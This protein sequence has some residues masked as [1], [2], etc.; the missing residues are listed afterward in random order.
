MSTADDLTSALSHLVKARAAY[1]KALDN[2]QYVQTG[3]R[4]MATHD[5]KELLDAVKYWQAEVN[6]LEAL[7]NG[8]ARQNI[9]PPLRFN[10]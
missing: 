6:R 5:L 4:R 10:L 9:N 8:T 3:Q 2:P 7:V 1:N